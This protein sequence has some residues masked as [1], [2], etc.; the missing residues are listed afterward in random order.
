M[1]PEILAAIEIQ[2]EVAKFLGVD[3]IVRE[4]DASSSLAV[5]DEVEKELAKS[6]LDQSQLLVWKMFVRCVI[7][8]ET[9]APMFSD[10][11]IPKLA[12]GSRSKISPLM[13]AFNRV[14]GFDAPENEKK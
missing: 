7:V 9:G 13:A 6:G 4:L 8:K 2:E 12:R 14:N 1:S 5:E 3:Y 11:D 10:A